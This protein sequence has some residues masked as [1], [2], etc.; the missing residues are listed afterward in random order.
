MFK[1]YLIYS[2]LKH[3][4]KKDEGETNEPSLKEANPIEKAEKD[5]FKIVEEERSKRKKKADE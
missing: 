2:I 1:L 4:K 3:E 5:F